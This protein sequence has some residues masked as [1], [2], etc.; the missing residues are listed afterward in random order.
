MPTKTLGEVKEEVKEIVADPRESA[1]RLLRE[2]RW[3][4]RVVLSSADRFY[5]DNGFS[6]AASLAYTTL[7]SLVPLMALAFGMFASFATS[8]QHL[9]QVRRFI[10]KQ[11]VPDVTSV[12][13]VVQYLSRFSESLSSLN[14][15]V[16]IFLVITSILL[17]NSIEY[18]LNEV[19][20]VYE[21]RTIAHRVAIFCA[22]LVI[23]PA[24]VISAY[25]F[26][27]S[28]VEPLLV[29]IGDG[30]W[31]VWTYNSMLPF[32]IDFLAFVSLYYL[33]PKA[34]VKLN[35]ACFGAFL[36]A[37]L[38]GLAKEGYAVY[39]VRF[40]SYNA[41]YTTLAAIPIS[42]LWLYIGWTLV[43]F[44]AELSY[45]AQN[46]PHHGKIWKRSIL[47]VGD[48][49]L[50]LA[51]QS[52]VIITRAFL[53]GGKLPNDIELAEALGCSSVVLKPALDALERNGII[54]RG[55]SRDM[56]LTLMRNPEKLT[57]AEVREALFSTRASIHFPQEMSRLFSCFGA[58]AADVSQKVTLADICSTA[59]ENINT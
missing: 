9:P 10:L 14:A 12:D 53:S 55:D 39:I 5:W 33:V 31:L 44:G 58:G 17:I 45:Q 13:T 40:S 1:Q 51:M 7:L 3:L 48:G 37:I 27:T 46:L 41:I 22:I 20:Q 54:C 57:L 15:I 23:A 16:I 18:A 19:W 28:R 30:S 21:P 43:L 50:L 26:S 25:Y 38:F 11:F 32:L 59:P 47:S 24:L 34:P 56:P 35:S 36:T 6:K 4:F 42:L 8:S 29:D 49:R 52:L 2:V